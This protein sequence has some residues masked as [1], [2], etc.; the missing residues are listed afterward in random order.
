M[1]GIA[2]L[3]DHGTIYLR[4]VNDRL[5]LKFILKN[6]N[7]NSTHAIHIHEFGDISKGCNS[8]GAHYN[9]YNLNHGGEN[10]IERHLGDLFNNFTTDNYGNFTFI[11]QYKDIKLQEIYGRSFVI[12]EFHDDCGTK[13]YEKYSYKELEKLCKERK[14]KFKRNKQAMIELLNTESLKSGNAGPRIDYG[15]I[16]ICDSRY[17]QYK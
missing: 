16:S 2:I 14:Y 1:F 17:F 3:K 6:F 4:Q 10:S 7:P 5:I 15:I 8:L 12:H 13:N 11:K 9:P